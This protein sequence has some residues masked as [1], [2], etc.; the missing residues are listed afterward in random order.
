MTNDEIESSARKLQI[1]IYKSRDTIWKHSDIPPF[2][3]MFSAEVAALALGISY[4]SH[5]NL[6]RFG[7]GHLR[8]EVA[9]VLNRQ[10]RRIVISQKFDVTTQRFTGAHEIGHWLLHPNELVMHRDRPLNGRGVPRDPR[11]IAER[12]ADYFAACFLAPRRV[13]IAEFEARF[14]PIASFRF[15]QYAAFGLGQRNPRSLIVSSEDSFEWEMVLSNA[16]AYHGHHFDS[17]AT[18]FGVSARTMALRLREIGLRTY[19]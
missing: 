12:D 8:F 9:G 7:D 13:V 14:G 16:T 10:A 18:A 19:R 5:T 6:G 11:P 15:D 2:S 3:R 4:E 17:L 1:E